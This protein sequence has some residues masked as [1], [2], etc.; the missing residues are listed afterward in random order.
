MMA[1]LLLFFVSILFFSNAWAADIIE[2][3]RPDKRPWVYISP[4]SESSV[5]FIEYYV[6]GFRNECAFRGLGFQSRADAI[7]AL[8]N[9]LGSGDSEI[10][11]KVNQFVENAIEN[12]RT[13]SREISHQEKLDFLNEVKE[14][15][16][17]TPFTRNR[18]HFGEWI[19][20]DR[21]YTLINALALI[22]NTNLYIYEPLN[23]L[24]SAGRG[25]FLSHAFS[26][27][28]TRAKINL[29]FK[30]G[31]FSSLILKSDKNGRFLAARTENEQLLE[32]KSRIE[33]DDFGQAERISYS[34]ILALEPSPISMSLLSPASREPNLE[35]SLAPMEEVVEASNPSSTSE[36]SDTSS[37]EEIVFF[38][39]VREEVIRKFVK[40]Y[41]ATKIDNFS[42]Q[43]SCELA[44]EHYQRS[45]H[46]HS[47]FAL[48][49]LA[50]E[51]KCGPRNQSFN[52]YLDSLSKT[53]I[54][55][56]KDDTC[57]KRD[58]HYARI[59][60]AKLLILLNKYDQAY[61]ILDLLKTKNESFTK[62]YL[63]DIAELI[64]KHGFIPRSMDLASAFDYARDLLANL[65][66][67]G[68]RAGSSG[69]G[70]LLSSLHLNNHG[71][72]RRVSAL[73]ENQNPRYLSH[74]STKGRANALRGSSL[75]AAND[76]GSDTL[77]QRRTRNNS[78]LDSSSS[79]D[80][81]EPHAK[82][83]CRSP[84]EESSYEIEN[85]SVESSDREISAED[86]F[87]ES[88]EED[89]SFSDQCR[90]L[91]LEARLVGRLEKDKEK[92]TALL[93]S[94]LDLLKQQKDEHLLA[95]VYIGLGNN[96]YT[97]RRHPH[98]YDWFLSAI[99]ILLIKPEINLLGRAYLGLGHAN[100]QGQK[101][102]WFFK[103]TEKL[104]D[105]N[106][107]IL[108]QAYLELGHINYQN[109]ASIWYQKANSVLEFEGAN[110]TQYA[111]TCLGLGNDM[112][113]PYELRKKWLLKA[114]GILK[115][116]SRVELLQ[117]VYLSLGYIKY[118]DREHTSSNEWFLEALKIS[119]KGID[120]NNIVSAMIALGN[121]FYTD[122][123]H[124]N[125][126]DWYLDAMRI[127][128]SHENPSLLAQ[129]YI[130]LGNAGYLGPNNTPSAAWYFKA[131]DLSR[132]INNSQTLARA[133]IGL[134]ND[135][136]KDNEHPNGYE[137]YLEALMNSQGL[138]PDYLCQI[139]IGLGNEEY[140]DAEHPASES[141]YY[142][143][144]DLLKNTNEGSIMA[145]AFVGLANKF[146]VGREFAR[147][148]SYCLQ[149]LK[150]LGGIK[151]PCLLAQIYI[152]LGDANYS[153]AR[154]PDSTAWYIEAVKILKGCP[155]AE[156][157]YARAYLGLG[158]ARYVDQEHL[159][160]L[161]WF[162]DVIDILRDSDEKKFLGQAYLGLGRGKY[163]NEALKWLLLAEA[164]LKNINEPR[165]I[166]NAQIA[167]GDA[168]HCD[169]V[170]LHSYD[171]YLSAIEKLGTVKESAALAH[172][173]IG[174]ANARYCDGAHP[175]D[176]DWYLDAIKVLKSDPNPFLLA[177][178]YIGLGNTRYTD[179]E[180]P[181]DYDWYLA[182]IKE[183]A[184][185]KHSNLVAKAYIGLGNTGYTDQ[186]HRRD[187]EWYLEAIKI[188]D[189]E[190]EP[191]VFAEACIG[192]GNTIYRDREHPIDGDW[193]W[194][195]IKV[196]EKENKPVLLARAYIGLGNASYQNERAK[197]FFK[198]EE[199]MGPEG[200]SKLRAQIY[201][202]L[203]NARHVCGNK[204]H[205]EWFERALEA[206]G[207]G[208]DSVISAQAYIGLG[209]ARHQNHQSKWYLKAL[210][211]L[212]DNGKARLR[213]QAYIGLGQARDRTD[214]N[215]SDWYRRAIETL[216]EDGDPDLLAK[217]YI[218]LGN[219]G[220][221]G[222][223]EQRAQWFFK[224]L[225]VLSNQKASKLHA[226]A[227]IGL[228]N[229][230][231]EEGP[232]SR[233][234]WFLQA[235]KIL[236][237]IGE[238]YF[239]AQAYIGLGNIRYTDAVCAHDYMWYLKAIDCLENS[240]E[241]TLLAQAYMGLGRARYKGTPCEW[242]QQAIALFG[243]NAEPRHLQEAYLGL[244]RAVKNNI[245][246]SLEYLNKALSF[247]PSSK[248][249]L[250]AIRQAED[251]KQ[252]LKQKLKQ[253][254]PWRR[255]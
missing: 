231:Y 162:L 145:R 35:P 169:S 163:Q 142:Q 92:A 94:A 96:F 117:E 167:L 118:T 245:D 253:K 85:P 3:A 28:G 54:D 16:Q 115:N 82:R 120:N 154:H 6:S 21:M 57:E 136:Y 243:P 40:D 84:L 249:V 24:N 127:L 73:G 177:N 130:G 178:A 250:G 98:D 201:V 171:W 128:E 140:T 173:Y 68:A 78:A 237:P 63:V 254:G 106:P 146:F 200:D 192:L 76:S 221:S 61:K 114:Y 228:A 81:D 229:S 216:G 251:Y 203:G 220:G 156:I 36:D 123:E 233:Q 31:H 90:L 20:S 248:V 238:T 255:R 131:I 104:A 165:L 213:A 43:V 212:G 244:G 83:I 44:L 242:F 133:F 67:M 172:A 241:R 181:N 5:E 210:D 45:R 189:S 46:R 39:A 33:N 17:L 184:S 26:V 197:W 188:V 148:Q 138:A 113:Q 174:L 125:D 93:L 69:N 218:G 86:N 64:I 88:Y 208:G 159:D 180:H 227:Y 149:A 222:K 252:R 166:A 30:G 65:P 97:D 8:I 66:R 108:S 170:H 199:I 205:A 164:A 137:W 129:A 23:P 132:Q 101:A 87:L 226:Q 232:L 139:Y 34:P 109:T 29:I 168:G 75:T 71:T 111:K 196:L 27:P 175:H 225:K 95:E 22:K 214:T 100:Y 150:A 158:F 124:P 204:S 194:A 77:L 41:Y 103:A 25:L 217:A 239:L 51:K 112:S 53:A 153:D 7:D 58:R 1:R 155:H 126:V 152:G 116:K 9:I 79:S 160:P 19:R 234:N 141:W 134:G 186:S 99:Q 246:L 105:G 179:R 187:W 110:G 157:L 135:R 230:R 91:I 11:N 224:A 10:K 60:A 89:H 176:Y 32:L 4:N 62:T 38:P 147:S 195:A 15:S 47:P 202:G 107:H 190:K 209:N 211:L 121:N 80:S 240:G 14:S 18:N 144:L 74:S 119:R 56:S 236:K 193:H 102:K 191:C 219:F 37:D 223:A 48:M 183:I 161:T 215:R 70:G 122:D 143:A 13:T 182:A 198:A 207:E 52:D 2:S 59:F 235:I 12:E 50:L 151:D 49:R 247:N 72:R 42:P 206:L 55:I 185:Q